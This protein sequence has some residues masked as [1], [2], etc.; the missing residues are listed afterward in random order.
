MLS[1][2]KLEVNEP[3]LKEPMATFGGI[4]GFPEPW[5]RMTVLETIKNEEVD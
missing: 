3:Q 2:I 1:T 5:W 4:L